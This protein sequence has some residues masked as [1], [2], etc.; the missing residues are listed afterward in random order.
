MLGS[1]GMYVTLN[2]YDD[3][4]SG[5]GLVSLRLNKEHPRRPKE[6]CSPTVDCETAVQMHNIFL[7]VVPTQQLPLIT[8]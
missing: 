3:L 6:K 8:R 1:V 7:V 5:P 2:R 4:G